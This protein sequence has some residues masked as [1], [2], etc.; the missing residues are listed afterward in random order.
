MERSGHFHQRVL[1]DPLHAGG[2]IG[3]ALAF[4][5][6]EINRFIRIARRTKEFDK[7]RRIA[8]LC[9]G[10]EF[11]IVEIECEPAIG[12]AADQLTDLLEQRWPSKGRQAHDFILVLIHLEAEIRRECRIQHS[13]GMR[14]SYFTQGPDRCGAVRQ[15]LAMTDR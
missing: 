6:F 13:K 5:S 7:A 10:V 9:S 2:T 1:E 3:E 11:K 15:S 12:R 4:R 14:K 8:A